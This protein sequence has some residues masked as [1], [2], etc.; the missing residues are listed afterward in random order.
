MIYILKSVYEQIQETI[1]SLPPEQGGVLGSVDGKIISAFYFDKTGVVS[2]ISYTPDY[3]K[4]NWI[5]EN[6]WTPQNIRMVGIIHSHNVSCSFPSCGDLVYGERILRSLEMDRFHLPIV[7]L[8]PF[9]INGY[10]IQID[11]NNN[12]KTTKEIVCIV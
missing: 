12:F 3:E 6:E 11:E 5:L 7:N 10:K 2:N 8:N 4:I 9:T 1:G